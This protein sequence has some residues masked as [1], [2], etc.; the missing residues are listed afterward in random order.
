MVKVHHCRGRPF[1][2]PSFGAALHQS[3]GA[4]QDAIGKCL[5]GWQ[6]SHVWEPFHVS[7]QIIATSPDLTPEGS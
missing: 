5:W 2:V 1:V 6:S 3:V 7:G 4:D